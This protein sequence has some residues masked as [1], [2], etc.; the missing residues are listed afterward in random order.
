MRVGQLENVIVRAQS[1]QHMKS[2]THFFV[3]RTPKP[4]VAEPRVG[5]RKN[6]RLAERAG[7]VGYHVDRLLE[8][9]LKFDFKLSDGRLSFFNGFLQMIEAIAQ[10]QT[11]P[12]PFNHFQQTNG[13]YVLRPWIF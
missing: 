11:G 9:G 4:V 8:F 13:D 7:N 1:G 2:P 6:S 10:G 12:A 3:E 5:Y